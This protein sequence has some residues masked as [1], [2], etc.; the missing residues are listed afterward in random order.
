[1]L[2]ALLASMMSGGGAAAAPKGGCPR[3]DA[4]PT[5]HPDNPK[6]R[7]GGAKDATLR[8]KGYHDRAE[9]PHCPALPSHKYKPGDSKAWKGGGCHRGWHFV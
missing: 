7:K 2:L 1:M 3:C 5:D 4:K 6:K 8:S 9:F